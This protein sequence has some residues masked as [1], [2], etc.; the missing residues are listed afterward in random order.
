M[1]L[2]ARIYIVNVSGGGQHALTHGRHALD[3]G[4]Q[5]SPD[6]D[7]LTF[8]RIVETRSRLATKILVSDSAGTHVHT[9][10]KKSLDPDSGSLAYVYEP[11]WDPDGTHLAYTLVALRNDGFIRSSL[12]RVA[13]DGGGRKLLRRDASAAT[14]SPSGSQISFSGTK[15]PGSH[16]CNAEDCVLPS[17][18]YVMRADGTHLKRLTRNRGEDTDPDWSADGQRIVFQSDRNQPEAYYE[19][20]ELYSIRPD[21]TCMTWLTKRH[22][23]KR[24]AR[25]AGGS[26]RSDRPRR[27]RRHQSAPA[28]GDRRTARAA[29]RSRGILA[30]EALSKP[31]AHGRQGS[32]S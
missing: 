18:I 4:P 25:L 2:G 9:V 19:S 22:S 23:P 32:G 7:S 27:V 3:Y 15:R 28:G 5:W 6:G 1:A 31:P 30:R 10:A 29:K 17:D 12:Y 14:Y 20:A 26:V 24:V 8:A 21:G 11:T 13:V 16:A